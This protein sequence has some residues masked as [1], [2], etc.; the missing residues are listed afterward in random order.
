MKPTDK[1]HD[2]NGAE[3]LDPVPMQ[4]PLGYKKTL[5]LSEQIAL[6]VRRMKLELLNDD[7]ISETE[8]EADDFEIGDDFEP[9]S[10][11][12]NDHIPPISVLKQRAKQIK[13]QIQE[14][15]RRAAI[16]AHE[17]ALKKP[18]SVTTPSPYAEPDTP[19]V[20]DKPREEL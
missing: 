11:Y 3:K 16:A 17:K 20:K 8:E 7:S 5:S 1:R 14:Q 15:N 18:Q 10:K 6:Q 9:L 4:P 2:E 19:S 13:E 12:E